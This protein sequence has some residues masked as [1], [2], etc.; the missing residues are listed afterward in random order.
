[1]GSRCQGW[2]QPQ[3]CCCPSAG[4]SPSP[5]A[6]APWHPQH[7]QQHCHPSPAWPT[8]GCR[9]PPAGLPTRLFLG[10]FGRWKAKWSCSSSP[11]HY[12]LRNGEPGRKP[13]P[14][15]WS[16]YD[17]RR[18]APTGDALGSLMRNRVGA[19]SETSLCPAA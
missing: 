5:G 14:G 12:T 19:S 18:S 4:A 7:L 10:G 9:P 17:S 16:R 11:K 1:M 6:A 8:C 3:P 2:C 13:R 15:C